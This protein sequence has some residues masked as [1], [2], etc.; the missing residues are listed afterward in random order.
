MRKDTSNYC[1]GCENLLKSTESGDICET[2]NTQ[3]SLN[4]ELDRNLQRALIDNIVPKS[5]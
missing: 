1:T 4:E 5:Q 3:N 2:C